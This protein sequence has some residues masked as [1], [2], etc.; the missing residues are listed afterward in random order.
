MDEGGRDVGKKCSGMSWQIPVES[1]V[2][3]GASGPI[4]LAFPAPLPGTPGR[5]R[6]RVFHG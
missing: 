3:S 1:V 2:G 5:E 6:S 4:V